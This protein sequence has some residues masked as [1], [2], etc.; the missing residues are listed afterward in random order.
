MG[1]DGELGRYYSVWREIMLS[2]FSRAWVW[3]RVDLAELSSS[4]FEQNVALKIGIFWVKLC[5][6]MLNLC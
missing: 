1:D 3:V 2:T 5:I 4:N 6:S